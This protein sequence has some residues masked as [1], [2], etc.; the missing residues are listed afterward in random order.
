MGGAT[1]YR[2]R[3]KLKHEAVAAIPVAALVAVVFLSFPRDA[4]TFHDTSSSRPQPSPSCEFV[5]LGEEQRLRAMA[6]VR[7]ALS[8]NASGAGNIHADLSRPALSEE[9]PRGV[10]PA[11]WRSRPAPLPAVAYGELP[12]PPTLAAPQPEAL[13]PVEEEPAKPAFTREELLV[14]GIE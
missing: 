9:A 8:V 11:E 10:M 4:A 3:R 1:R 7:S 12:L 2:P 13:A 6:M 14:P 5:T